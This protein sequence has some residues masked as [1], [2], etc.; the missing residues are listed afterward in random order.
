MKDI[1]PNLNFIK[2]PAFIKITAFGIIVLSCFYLGK[3]YSDGYQQLSFF[4]TFHSPQIDVAVGVSPNVGKFSDQNLNLT[5]PP[6]IPGSPPKN[7]KNAPPPA[8]ERIGIVDEDGAMSVE[9]E[10]GE[11]DPHSVE[12]LGNSDGEEEKKVGNR[13]STVKIENFRVCEASMQD[14]IPCLDNVEEIARL[15]S[16]ERGEKYE[17]HCPGKGEGLDC[18]V[19]MPQG[20]KPRIP[21]PASRDEV[22]FSNVPHTRLVEDKGGQNW[23][24]IKG[25][26][27]VFPGGGTQFIHGADQ[28]LDQ[29]SQMVPDIAFGNHT[30]VVLDIGCG[31]ASFG[32]FLLQRNVITL[33]IA[34][35]DV[36]ENQIQFALERGVPAMVAVFATHR[37]LYPSQAFDLIHCSR[38][39][40][41]WTRDDGILLL[42]VNRMLRAGGYFAWAAQPVYKH[43]GNL[44]EQ[45]KEMEDLTIRLCWELVKKEGY[46]A[47]WRKPLN[48]SC[49]LNRDTGVQPPLCDPN[50]DPDDVCWILVSAEVFHKMANVRNKRNLLTKVR[51]NDTSLFEESEIE[52]EFRGI[53]GAIL[54]EEAFVALSSLSGDK[55]TRFPFGNLLQI[56]EG[57][58]YNGVEIQEEISDVERCYRVKARKKHRLLAF[59]QFQSLYV[60]VADSFSLWNGLSDAFLVKKNLLVGMV[61][62]YVGM[63]PCIT[64]LPENGYGANVTAW[65]ARLNDLPERLQTIE[66]DAYISRKEIL[67]ADTKFWHE[68]IYG[69]VHAY[70]WND[71]KL[72]N[73]MDMRA[74]FG[75]FAAALIDFQVDCWVMNVVPVSGFNTLPVIYDRGLIG[76]R[77]DWKQIHYKAEK[78]SMTAFHPL[79]TSNVEALP[80]PGNC[81][82]KFIVLVFMKTYGSYLYK[83]QCHPS[84]VALKICVHPRVLK[85]PLVPFHD[86][87]QI[88]SSL[89]YVLGGPYA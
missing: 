89:N 57:V 46:I 48:N 26:K 56:Y 82:L 14:Y 42:E 55:V 5:A 50:D 9:F 13:D 30:R 58:G 22:W 65:P 88:P 61:L 8:V 77:H 68:V 33:S 80:W 62:S 53:K 59:P 4:S 74:G 87:A 19:P 44:Q 16:T 43:E 60:V 71:S 20:Y 49:Y 21:W 76:V 51:V 85:P 28:Y 37:L 39:R 34:P 45:W 78:V 84:K 40:I 23:I 2:T 69:Y 72:R 75:G 64:L 70:H 10:V 27:F 67:K 17:R 36:H 7:S 6:S 12:D 1:G 63:K 3:H 86:N 83:C 81:L 38:C 54:K 73:V 35:K 66:M 79:K 47:I 18:L 15:N 41:N 29:I 31:V 11:F 32:A 25:D 24:S 52:V